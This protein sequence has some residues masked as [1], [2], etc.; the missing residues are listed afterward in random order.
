MLDEKKMT[1]NRNLSTEPSRVNTDIGRAIQKIH[2]P[3]ESSR[4]SE[5]VPKPGRD[6]GVEEEWCDQ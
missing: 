2:D 3:G 5:V 1:K 4:T 6:R